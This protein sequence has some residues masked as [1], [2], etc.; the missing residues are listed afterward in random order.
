M[1]AWPPNGYCPALQSHFAIKPCIFLGSGYIVLA[2]EAAAHLVTADEKLANAMATH[3]P[4]R[5]L[6]P[7]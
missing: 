6:G 3:F 2:R 1:P 7:I 4:V 5:W